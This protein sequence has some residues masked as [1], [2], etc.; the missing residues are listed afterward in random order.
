MHRNRGYMLPLD[1]IFYALYVRPFALQLPQLLAISKY[2][3]RLR[4]AD[5]LGYID[6][7][8]HSFSLPK[9]MTS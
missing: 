2:F 6:G 7:Y 9:R 3:I 8:Q 4:E 5:A 1:I